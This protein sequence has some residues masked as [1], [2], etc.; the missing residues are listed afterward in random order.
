MTLLEKSETPEENL[1]NPRERHILNGVA[2]TEFFGK[3]RE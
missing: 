1:K 2:L 3:D